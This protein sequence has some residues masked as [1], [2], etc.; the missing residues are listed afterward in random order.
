MAHEI[1]WQRQR[2]SDLCRLYAINAFYGENYISEKQ[3]REFCLLYNKEYP[4]C[5]VPTSVSPGH[6]DSI[7]YYNVPS[8]NI[9]LIHYILGFTNI[10]CEYVPPKTSG[11]SSIY[12]DVLLSNNNI[13]IEEFVG[14]SEWIFVFDQGHTWG[15]KKLNGEWY[16][17]DSLSGVSKISLQSLK[18]S[19]NYGLI[20]P[21]SKRDLIKILMR[22]KKFIKHY[23]KKNNINTLSNFQQFINNQKKKGYPIGDLEIPIFVYSELI[24]DTSLEDNKICSLYKTIKEKMARQEDLSYELYIIVNSIIMHE[25]IS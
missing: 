10:K 22:Y 8:N 20:I 4:D 15:M 24:L 19:K 21:R 7:V 9:T 1:Y 11:V 18:S 17:V 13:T 23:V 16:K 25:I 6:I 3:F 14:D 12:L 5:I 2:S